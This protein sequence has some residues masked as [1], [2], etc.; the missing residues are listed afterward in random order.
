MKI[1]FQ[2][3]QPSK[4]QIKQIS[5]IL[6]VGGVIIYPTDSVYAIGADLYNPKAISKLCLIARKEPTVANLSLICHNLSQIS[7]FTNPFS[8]SI[9]RVMNKSLPG[10][11][12]FILKANNNVPKLFKNKKRTIGIRVPDNDIARAIVEELGNPII[13]SSIKNPLD[14]SFYIDPNDVYEDYGKLVDAV[15]FGAIGNLDISTIIDCTEDEIE[16]VR[17]GKGDFT[18]I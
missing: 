1:E 2:A 11:F 7:L 4:R 5:E 13:T 15:V 18:L 6:K 12:T 17:E 16:V 9:Y 14:D 8:T 3:N 10:P